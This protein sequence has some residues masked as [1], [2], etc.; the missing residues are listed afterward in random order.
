MSPTELEPF[1]D[2]DPVP[3]LRLTLASG[4]QIIIT[5]EDKPFVVGFALI[6]KGDRQ[7]KSV[8]MGSKVISV[9]N[10]VMAETITPRYRDG[11][12]HRIR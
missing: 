7:N 3:N 6:L 10:I 5:A 4:D 2:M 9:P 11:G 8:I 1:L 12:R